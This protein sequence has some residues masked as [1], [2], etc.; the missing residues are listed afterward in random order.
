MTKTHPNSRIV[1]FH[2]S[3]NFGNDLLNPNSRSDYTV[4]Q[5]EVVDHD[6][7]DFIAEIISKKLV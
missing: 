3:S 4:L 5:L 1:Q 2:S 7:Y 6:K